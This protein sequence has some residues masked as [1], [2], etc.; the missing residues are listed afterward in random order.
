MRDEL[1]ERFPRNYNIEKKY[2][3]DYNDLKKKNI[4][5]KDRTFN[6]IF[7]ISLALGFKNKC[8]KNLKSP[9]PVVNCN[10]FD[11]KST[12]IIASLAI[13]EKGIGVLSD[14]VEIRKTA[15]KYANGGFEIL[16][17]K[18]SSDDPGSIIKRFEEELLD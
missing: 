10:A 6:D 17:K 18:L 16:K 12:W 5:F 9:Y 1:K 3:K 15:E 14:M 11:V 2:Q 13:K 4:L 7:M 8:P